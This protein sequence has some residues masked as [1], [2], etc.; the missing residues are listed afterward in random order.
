MELLPLEYKYQGGVDKL[1]LVYDI[2]R[3]YRDRISKF[4]H[5][6]SYR[7]TGHELYR[8]HFFINPGGLFSDVPADFQYDLHVFVSPYNSAARFL[9]IEFNP[10]NLSIKII[11]RIFDLM[12]GKIQLLTSVNS[13]GKIE[14]ID[15]LENR[16][17]NM[18]DDLYC[19]TLDFDFGAGV[20]NRIDL[21]IDVYD[22]DLDVETLYHFLKANSRKNTVF[23]KNKLIL[24]RDLVVNLYSELEKN[25]ELNEISIDTAKVVIIDNDNLE[26]FYLGSKTSDTFIRCYDKYKESGEEKYLNCIRIERQINNLN[27]TLFEFVSELPE[28][29]DFKLRAYKPVSRKCNFCDYFSIIKNALKYVSRNLSKEYD[30]FYLHRSQ[31]INKLLF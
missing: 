1:T 16:F 11:Y 20:I 2:P 12:C 24:S 19:K 23:L 10:N 18:H 21:N 17:L 13:D 27:K 14:K 30:T 5:N 3:L 4:F 15:R 25:K 28:I 26:G 8:C 7:E 9:R 22:S 29:F 6:I 31:I